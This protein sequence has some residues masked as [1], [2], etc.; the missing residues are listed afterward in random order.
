MHRAGLHMDFYISALLASFPDTVSRV[1]QP[2]ART[3]PA[4]SPQAAVNNSAAPVMKSSE[5][6]LRP[7]HSRHGR[8]A[9]GG[10]RSSVPYPTRIQRSLPARPAAS[11]PTSERTTACEAPGIRSTLDGATM[12]QRKAKHMKSWQELTHY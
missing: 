11:V 6:D 2:R 1:I 4:S 8:I 7:R 5:K 10:S 3:A 12:Q 9:L